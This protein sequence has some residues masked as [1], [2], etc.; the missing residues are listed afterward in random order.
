MFAD[1]DQL[2]Y[3]N[4]SFGH[5]AGSQMIVDAA[6]VLQSTFREC[7]ILARLGGDEFIVLVVDTTIDDVHYISARLHNQMERYNQ[8]AR[9]A[10]E[11]S[12]SVGFAQLN[13][14][15]DGTIEQAI[16]QADQAMYAHKRSKRIGRTV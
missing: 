13:P 14:K 8:Q 11:L 5:H 3:T 4:D 7:D 6:T 1:L 12:M 2:K 16:A 9:R 15:L 10:Y